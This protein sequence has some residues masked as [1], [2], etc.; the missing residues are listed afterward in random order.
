LADTL[1]FENCGM[2][3]VDVS[4]VAEKPSLLSR[5]PAQPGDASKALP[6]D[7]TL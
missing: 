4:P 3:Y 7:T 6:A 1:N 5:L 2:P